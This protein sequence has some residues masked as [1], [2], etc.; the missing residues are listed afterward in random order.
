MAMRGSY[1]HNFIAKIWVI[2]K[3]LNGFR[4]KILQGFKNLYDSINR[5]PF[6]I[7][8]SYTSKIYCKFISSV[9]IFDRGGVKEPRNPATSFLDLILSFPGTSVILCTVGR[10]QLKAT[11]SSSRHYSLWRTM[12]KLQRDNTNIFIPHKKL[13]LGWLHAETSSCIVITATSNCLW[14]TILF[15]CCTLNQQ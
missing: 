12:R 10:V 13:L 15:I 6:T 4:P 9:T 14:N 11:R 5:I 3:K 7:Y 8:P 1:V 2:P